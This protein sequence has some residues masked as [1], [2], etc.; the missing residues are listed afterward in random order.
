MPTIV[1]EYP[2]KDGEPVQLDV[3]IGDLQPGG[4]SVFVDENNLGRHDNDIADLPLGTGDQLRGKALRV[5]TVVKDKNPN[6]NF[7][8]TVVI[9]DGGSHPHLEIPQSENVV[10]G[11]TAN[12]L[13]VVRFV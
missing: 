13:T 5:S 12:F 1:T 2:V 3:L 9:L 6:T 7:V 11:G 4:T 10:P 8:S